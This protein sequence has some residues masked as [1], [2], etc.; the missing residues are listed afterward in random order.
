MDTIEIAW[1]GFVD[2]IPLNIYDIGLTIL[3]LLIVVVIQ[4]AREHWKNDS[5][6]KH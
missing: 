5:T 4:L 2:A 3:I 1:T 6:K